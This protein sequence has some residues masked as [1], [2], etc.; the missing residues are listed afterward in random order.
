MKMIF[1]YD[2]IKT[3]FRYKSLA[4]SLV[5][6]VRFFGTRKWP[7]VVT[8][9]S[10]MATLKERTTTVGNFRKIQSSRKKLLPSTF[11]F[12]VFDI[13]EIFNFL[14]YESIWWFPPQNFNQSITRKSILSDLQT[15]SFLK[16]LIFLV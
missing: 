16:R 14:L 4:R 10:R 11:I 3:Y 7:I 1:N 8:T 12:I 6:R 9:F 5:L 13:Q 2:A 15:L